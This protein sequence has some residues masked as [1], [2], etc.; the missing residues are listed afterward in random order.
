MVTD[1][2]DMILYALS[3]ICVDTTTSVRYDGGSQQNGTEQYRIVALVAQWRV[4]VQRAVTS[5]IWCTPH[6]NVTTD[7]DTRWWGINLRGGN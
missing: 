2:S 7:D 1:V 5:L 6:C 4:M 3:I